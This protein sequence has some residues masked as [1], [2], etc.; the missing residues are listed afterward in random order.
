[1]K[2]NVTSIA[3]RLP[4]IAALAIL[5]AGVIATVSFF[6]ARA[7]L[8]QQVGLRLEMALETRA[9]RL[10][11]WLQELRS[12]AI[13]AAHAP[14]TVTALQALS[15]G[16]DRVEGDR[17]ATLRKL[18][19]TDNRY[20]AAE[21]FKL[22][23]GGDGS[24][25]S[26]AHA[27]FHG[28]FRQQLELRGYHDLVLFDSQGDLIYS[29][30]KEPD[31]AQDFRQAPLRDSGLG[32]AY[33][34]AMAAP[35]QSPVFVDFSRYGPS[36]D[37]AAAFVA[38]RVEGAGNKPLGVLAF[39]VNVDRLNAAING[40]AGL[41]DNGRVILIGADGLRRNSDP[42]GATGDNPLDPVADRPQVAALLAGGAGFLAD[43]LGGNGQRVMASYARLDEPGLD[44]GLVVEEDRAELMAP[45]AHLREH[46][47]LLMLA[48]A[49]AAVL[50]GLAL[51]R[52]IVRPLL[53]IGA[54]MRRVADGDYHAEVPF[55]RRRDE[56]GAIAA[57]LEACRARLADAEE[58]ARMTL[59]Q[60]QAFAESSVPM[61]MVDSRM[62]VIAQNKAAD[63][64][65]MD[66][67]E[68]MRRLMPDYDAR[69]AVG[70][71]MDLF[72][73][74]PAEQRRL[75]ADLD[76]LPL[77]TDFAFGE[78]RIRRHVT[79]ILDSAG[80]YAG[81]IV[82]F[83][84]VREAKLNASILDALRASQVVIEY[85]SD[86]RVRKV[87]A[88]FAEVFGYGEEAIGMSIEELFG[89]SEDTVVA[90]ERLAEG[91]AVNHKVRR[92]GRDG[93]DVW[94]DV[95]MNPIFDARGRLD[96][97]VELSHDVSEI[98]R[99]RQAVEGEREKQAAAQKQVVDDLRRGLAALAGG[100]LTEMLETPF[101][102]EYEQLRH[103]FNAALGK[104]TDVMRQLIAIT[105]SINA[106]ATEMSQAADDLSRRTEN[107]AATLE[108]TA[109]A[110]DQL[111][112]GV[113][114]AADGAGEADRA[115][116]SAR[117]NAT[118][119]G[120]VV[121]QAVDAMGEIEKS[122]DQISQIIGVIDD[123][124]F[125]TNLLALNAGVEAARA[126]EAGRGFA[127]VASEVRSLAQR[128]SEAA[129][130]I[131]ALISASSGHVERGVTLVGQAGAALN[132]IVESVGHIAGLVTDIAASS[133]EQ[134][135]GLIEINTG[136]TQLDEVTQQ[137]AAM[138]EETTAASHSL[139]NESVT[140]SELV[141]RFR[142]RPAEGAEIVTM[143][144][145]PRPSAGTA[146]SEAA[147]P[148]A[149]AGLRNG[150]EWDG[151]EEF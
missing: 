11:D 104:L 112:A 69:N 3:V 41:A 82:E 10:H 140:L 39:E 121:S 19:V 26:K 122:S 150:T 72:H 12:D 107:Q 113:K 45:V 68:T 46:A 128:S 149:G 2:L 62:V 119:S 81:N 71:S 4:V 24:A 126:G 48:A 138:V 25:Y 130:E 47:I 70:M 23:G 83:S 101:S 151:W 38:I 109:A 120:E 143:R 56:I 100:N 79:A 65:F 141:A 95:A 64:L 137:N 1:M 136:V 86:F 34:R 111:T 85:D 91:E 147:N 13:M 18:Y 21:R 80:N 87:N 117:E 52:S 88:K 60:S 78:M 146:L 129:R 116:R 103:D 123:I 118:A 66:N 77:S 105:G 134:S 145:A 22:A 139:R 124:A 55:V 7:A 57:D 98:E 20:P 40:A 6:D 142:V 42:G 92:K 102:P 59:F 94:V 28:L 115:V 97:V 61:V 114:S 135:N 74:D 15:A 36:N 93:R 8:T 148:G 29:V 27:R 49:V 127:V 44:W 131:K 106:G 51:A 110:M 35:D 43:T 73:S 67:V 9:V 144:R 5:F 133:A 50:M 16:F 75:F 96:Q 63:R 99:Q 125:Q 33:R 76:N 30:K 89:A 108:E 17:A 32:R 31:F 53:G 58:A 14:T 132:Q 37:V 90:R 84:D 54:A